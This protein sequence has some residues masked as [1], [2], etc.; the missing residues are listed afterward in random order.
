MNGT[1]QTAVFETLPGFEGE[2]P[3][4]TELTL[5]GAVG[6]RTRAMK[7][8]ESLVLVVEVQV[9]GVN[10]KETKGGILRAHALKVQDAYEL[11]DGRAPD[12]LEE[13]HNE[14]QA[15]EDEARGRAKLPFDGDDG[16]DGATAAAGAGP[17]ARADERADRDDDGW[18]DF[19]PADD[20]ELVAISDAADLA[21][22]GG[23]VTREEF[24]EQ[25][26][27]LAG[28]GLEEVDLGEVPPHAT[29]P[30]DDPVSTGTYVD[31]TFVADGE[32]DAASTP[33]D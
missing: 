3:V 11:G 27:T 22:I 32:A 31:G 9:T 6:R 26:E 25:L 21:A 20:P 12:L 5:S 14:Y 30:A 16:P 15:A 19:D 1:R 18:G 24:L 2:K 10:H 33:A 4:G 17:E 13:L 28:D 8:G 29:D 23:A 7:I